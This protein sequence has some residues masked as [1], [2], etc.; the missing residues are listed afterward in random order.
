MWSGF[1]S[2]QK[3]VD[4]ASKIYFIL[5]LDSQLVVPC[6]FAQHACDT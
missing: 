6:S 5:S 1:A 4:D 3:S 2:V